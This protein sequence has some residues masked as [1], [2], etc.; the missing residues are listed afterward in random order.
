MQ[1]NVLYYP[2][3]ALHNASLAK[4]LAL[5]YDHVY[6]IVPDN[7]R[8]D[9][10]EE[11]QPLLEEGLIGGMIDPVPYSLSASDEFLTKLGEWD[12]AALDGDPDG[13]EELSR[14]HVDKTDQRVRRLFE[15]SG[16]QS[17][18]GWMS[19]PTELASNYMLY[20]AT[21]IAKKNNLSLITADWG[22]WTGISYFNLDGKIDQSLSPDMMAEYVDD[23]FG[24]FCLVINGIT[25]VNIHEIPAD[26]ILEFRL[27]RSD[28]ITSFRKCLNDL[29]EELRILDANEIKL[30]AIR[31]KIKELDKAKTNYQDSADLIKAK[32]WTGLKMIGFPAPSVFA[33]LMDIPVAST[34][35][36]GVTGLALGALYTIKS[37]EQDL[38]KLNRENPAS[39]LIELHRSF[40]KYTSARGGGDINYHAWNCME[41]FIND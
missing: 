31:D 36:L 8:P 7:V 4:A 21:A 24:L 35:T 10:H 6:R 19:I 20:L 39:F 5:F 37:N 34:I 16:Y 11:L 23:P 38:K 33:H 9:D 29:H 40:K 30:D 27:K 41:E 2:H 28:E 12:A 25:P 32:G 26:K 15:E 13:E 22:A 1:K 3:I 14:L 17:S 18:D